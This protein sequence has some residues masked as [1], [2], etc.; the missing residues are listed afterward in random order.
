MAL[1]F[2]QFFC[3]FISLLKITI[4]S[5][6]S[7]LLALPYRIKQRGRFLSVVQV[8]MGYILFMVKLIPFLLVRLL[9]WVKKIQ[10]EFGISDWVIHHLQSFNKF[11]LFLPLQCKA[12]LLLFHF[13]NTVALVKV[14]C[15]HLVSLKLLLMI[16]WN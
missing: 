16:H 13:V 2:L 10:L 1:K 4:V 11:F 8:G 5:L 15:C 9:F 6:S 14:V 3:Q 7:M 12:L